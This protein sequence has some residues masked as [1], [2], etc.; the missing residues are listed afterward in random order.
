MVTENERSRRFESLNG[1]PH[2]DFRL[3][4]IT[5]SVVG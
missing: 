2:V 3:N 5:L 4:F 1:G